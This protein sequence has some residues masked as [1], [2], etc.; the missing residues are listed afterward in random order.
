[1]RSCV[2]GDLRGLC[3]E[4]VR[5]HGIPQ[6]YYGRFLGFIAMWLSGR[7]RSTVILEI[8]EA[9]VIVGAYQK[10]H[11]HRPAPLDKPADGRCRPEI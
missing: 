11:V 6:D 9:G 5:A 10:R 3:A 2:L 4:D 7:P 1:M 8:V